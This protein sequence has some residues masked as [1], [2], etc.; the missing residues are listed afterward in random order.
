M[1]IPI[2]NLYYLFLYA[3]KRF[4]EASVVETGVEQSPD[5]PNL[6]AQLLALGTRKLIRRGLDRGYRTFTDDLVQPRGRLLLD[7]IIKEATLLKGKVACA[8]DELT[9]DILPNQVLKATLRNLIYCSD[10]DKKLKYELR[11]VVRRLYDI[12]DINVHASHFR[13][14]AVSQNN[15]EYGF[16]IAVCEFVFRTLMPEEEG[17][18][19][20]FKDILADEHV[21]REVFESFLR[22]FYRLRRS[23]YHV[24]SEFLQWD[25]R[26]ATQEDLAFLP[27][28]QTDITMRHPDHVIIIDAKFYPKA[29]IQGKY[30][31]GERVRGEQLFQLVAYLE[32]ERAKKPDMPL[33]GMLIYPRAGP[34]LRLKYRLLGLPILVATVNLDRNWHDIELELDGLLDECAARALTHHAEASSFVDDGEHGSMITQQNYLH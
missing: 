12:K 10:V 31:G 30:G 34:E 24:G 9:H 32:N 2:R 7:R 23:E 29:L 8:F 27:R 18:E 19:S 26:D 5:L 33:S 22:N 28:M 17:A 6:F 13:Q 21:M 1:N 25:V 16:L 14:I 11:S 15:R 3:W 20:R 4:P